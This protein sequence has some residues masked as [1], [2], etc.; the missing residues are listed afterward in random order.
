M[1]WVECDL[2][3]T[4]DSKKCVV[5]KH[6]TGTILVVGLLGSSALDMARAR[7]VSAV[8]PAS[9]RI[10]FGPFNGEI[11]VDCEMEV[12]WRDASYSGPMDYRRKSN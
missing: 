6:D 8:S 1:V 7:L 11:H 9:A 10:S 3:R 4:F 2:I 5:R 12:D